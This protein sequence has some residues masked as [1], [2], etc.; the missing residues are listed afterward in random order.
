MES[1]EHAGRCI[2]QLARCSRAH[3]AQEADA[4]TVLPA[5]RNQ[6]CCCSQAADRRLGQRA[7]REQHVAQLRLRPALSFDY[8]SKACSTPKPGAHPTLL[9]SQPPTAKQAAAHLRRQSGALATQTWELASDILGHMRA[10]PDLTAGPHLRQ[11]SEEVRLILH[12]VPCQRQPRDAIAIYCRAASAVRLPDGRTP[13]YASV[14]TRGDTV[15][16]LAVF[17]AQILIERAELHPAHAHIAIFSRPK[18]GK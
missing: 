9:E 18:P 11:L 4:L 5:L 3:L 10:E 2:P 6:T 15:E 8:F 17:S 1:D 16:A 13:D 7:Q 14:V 12:G